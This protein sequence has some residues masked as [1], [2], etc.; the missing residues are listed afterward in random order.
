MSRATFILNPT[1]R[2]LAIAAVSNAPDGMAVEVREPTRSLEQ[3]AALWRALD[4]IAK[5]VPWHGLKLSAEDWKCLLSASLRKDLR[6]VP[7]LDN[8]GF[9][10]LGM[11][12]S[13]MTKREFSDLLELITCFG[14]QHGVDFD[15]R[16]ED[17]A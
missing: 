6:V 14:A 17:A 4:C 8:D 2:I 3:N 10:V 9:V 1:S 11:R 5:Q 13:Q 12:T 7:N 15:A 16:H